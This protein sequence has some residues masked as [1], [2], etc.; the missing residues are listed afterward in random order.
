MIWSHSINPDTESLQRRGR[1]QFVRMANEGEMQMQRRT[2]HPADQHRPK[3]RS[4]IRYCAT[5]Q[6]L[7]CFGSDSSGPCFDPEKEA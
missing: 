2:V 1:L 4:E 3:V 6:V 7:W 5:V